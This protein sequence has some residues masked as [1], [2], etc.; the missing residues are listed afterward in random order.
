MDVRS[1]DQSNVMK[2]GRV[3]LEIRL[4]S[5][6]T[7]VFGDETFRL[8]TPEALKL[9]VPLAIFF[10]DKSD[11]STLPY[12]DDFYTTHNS[13]NNTERKLYFDGNKSSIFAYLRPANL[14]ARLAFHEVANE[15]IEGTDRFKHA[16]QFIHI[17]DTKVSLDNDHLTETESEDG[18]QQEARREIWNGYYYLS[19]K[20]MPQAPAIGW[21][22]GGGRWEGKFGNKTN[23]RVDLLLAKTRHPQWK[24]AGVHARFAFL[25]NGSFLVCV[26]NP[27]RP[28][29]VGDDD[30]ARDG[31]RVLSRKNRISFGDLAYEFERAPQTDED[32]ERFQEQL[33]NFLRDFLG[34]SSPPPDCSATPSDTNYVIGNWIVTGTVGQGSF[35]TVSAAKHRASGAEAAAKLVIRNP[36]NTRGTG[37]EIALA[38]NL[39]KHCY[40]AE[41]VD[42]V[43]ERGNR[44]YRGPRPERVHLI[45]K[46]LARE[47]LDVAKTLTRNTSLCL[48]Q[49]ALEGIN[50]LHRHNIIHRDVKPANLG[51]VSY[52]VPQIVIFD[53]GQAIKQA[54]VKSTPGY[55]GTIP[56]LAPEMQVK[57]EVY[58]NRVDIWALGVVGFQLFV[59]RGRS[60]WRSLLLEK[61]RYQDAVKVLHDAPD[62]SIENLLY[63]ML[64]WDQS[65]RISAK[66]ALE[67]SC[68]KNCGTDL[69]PETHPKTGNKH[70]LEP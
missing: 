10:P 16:Q 69:L 21:Q 4:R 42:V 43:Y 1:D 56:Y 11:G 64:E 53:F 37:S 12:P 28:V 31:S 60:P 32:E 65:Q 6:K 35:G 26:D 23:G 22:L 44:W 55:I 40:L 39:P 7:P 19:F 52:T 59:T 49:Q 3:R 34:A 27:R 58:T 36:R 48:F 29:V 54:E 38:R 68:F 62:D 20:T 46:P 45:W 50:E 63:R 51:I 66:E 17:E 33:R 24:L 47:T 57:G 9:R 61:S 25:R 5:E 18:L 8:S 2:R 13:L 70:A 41:L 14:Q 67:H 15:I 30:I